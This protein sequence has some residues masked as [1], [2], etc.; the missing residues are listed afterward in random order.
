MKS[1]KLI[2][3]CTLLA[4]LLVPAVLTAQEPAAPERGVFEFGF[5]GVTGEVYGRTDRARFR[6]A[7][8]SAP[9]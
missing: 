2:A 6:S 7:T 1:F 9:I 8:T 5:R 4:L 3:L